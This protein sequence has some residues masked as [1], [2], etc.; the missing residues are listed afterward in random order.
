MPPRIA[1][2]APVPDSLIQRIGFMAVGSWLLQVGF[3]IYPAA[4]TRIWLV[5]P[6]FGLYF[7]GLAGF[8]VA[9]TPG[10]WLH[11]G[12]T[13]ILLASL[14]GVIVGFAVEVTA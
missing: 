7:L 14:V 6:L 5:P 3:R 12:R 8:W 11:H 4:S 9:L 13:W 1:R 2:P 10:R